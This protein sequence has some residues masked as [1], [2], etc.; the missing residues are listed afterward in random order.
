MKVQVRRTAA[1]LAWGTAAMLVVLLG[2]AGTTGGRQWLHRVDAN[3]LG[4]HLMDSLTRV[5]S[6]EDW[7]AAPTLRSGQN[8]IW[9]RAADPALR[10]AHALGESGAPTANTLA[11][12]ARAHAAGFLLLEVD[13][14]EEAGELR[15]Q[16][17]PGPQ[18][19]QWNDGCTFDTLLEA[20]PSD[21]WLVL[22]IKTTFETAGRRV[23]DRVKGSDVARRIIFQLYRPEDVALFRRWQSEADLPGPIVTA[24]LSHR[25]IDHVAAHMARIGGRA[26]AL[27]ID[28][29]PALSHRP[30]DAVT[31]VH[32][33]R[34][35]AA[36]EIA[37]R[38]ADGA[39]VLSTLNCGTWSQKDPS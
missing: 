4:E 1:A 9:L 17:D 6:D 21:A 11:A 20:L 13:L 10:I 19:S 31:L 23:V 2:L 3:L 39:Y 37:R 28:R 25:R 33:V 32:P 12:A 26:L 7:A 5:H 35:C 18:V 16:H 14:V 36:W 22:D 38:G 30:E 27:P 8:Y 34:D 24:Y 15:C 29:L